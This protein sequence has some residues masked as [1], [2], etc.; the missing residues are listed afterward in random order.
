MIYYRLGIKPVSPSEAPVEGLRSHFPTSEPNASTV[1]P[2]TAQEPLNPPNAPP[3]ERLAASNVPT[4]APAC[5]KFP[6]ILVN[7]L[8][9]IKAFPELI[10]SVISTFN[11][12]ASLGILSVI[13]IVT[14]F[15]SAEFL[16]KLI[17]F[18]S[19]LHSFLIF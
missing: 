19:K 17:S 3:P 2:R 11:S 16:I 1:L 9:P 7:F 10:E 6:D 8:C 14:P 18:V 12:I 5:V 4:V 13:L 15:L